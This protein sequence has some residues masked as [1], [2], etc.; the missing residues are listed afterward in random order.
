MPDFSA[1]FE[2]PERNTSR[3]YS[4]PKH[5]HLWLRYPSGGTGWQI[6]KWCGLTRSP[7]EIANAPESVAAEG[8]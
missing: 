4:L 8:G 5:A 7:D 6:C 2:G 1:Q 3:P